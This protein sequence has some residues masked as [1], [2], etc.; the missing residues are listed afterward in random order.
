MKKQTIQN[1]KN[2]CHLRFHFIRG[3]ESLS[4]IPGYDYFEEVTSNNALWL[5]TGEENVEYYL[6]S[7]IKRLYANSWGCIDFVIKRGK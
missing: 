3:E 5:M 2:I 7:P 1:T 6:G 4:D